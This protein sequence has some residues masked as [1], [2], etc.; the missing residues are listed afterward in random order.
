MYLVFANLNK[1]SLVKQSDK[2]KGYCTSVLKE[3]WYSLG[4]F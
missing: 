2:Y 3:K 1:G 4:K